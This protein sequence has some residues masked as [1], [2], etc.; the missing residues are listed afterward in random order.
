M[1]NIAS[2]FTSEKN[3]ESF[4][5][6]GIKENMK[7]IYICEKLNK[8]KPIIEYE[9]IFGDNI[10]KMKYILGRFN[11]NMKEREK[12]EKQIHQEIL[13]CDPQQFVVMDDK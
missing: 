4:C 6:C 1:T 12:L 5:I 3:N 9:Q 10:V 7:H 13:Y 11:E 8:E 2:N